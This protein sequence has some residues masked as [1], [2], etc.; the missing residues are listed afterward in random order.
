MAVFCQN[1]RLS[2]VVSAQLRPPVIKIYLLAAY[3]RIGHDGQGVSLRD[4][5]NSWTGPVTGLDAARIR[6]QRSSAV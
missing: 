3:A 4:R 1:H 2:H 5:D 6:R